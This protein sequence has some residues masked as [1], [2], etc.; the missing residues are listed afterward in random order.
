MPSIQLIQPI[1]IPLVSSSKAMSQSR[2]AP[3]QLFDSSIKFHS[4]SIIS[5]SKAISQSRTAPFYP[6]L[7]ASCCRCQRWD[8]AYRVLTEMKR[9][10]LRPLD[11]R[12]SRLTTA[13]GGAGE[14]RDKVLQLLELLR[15]TDSPEQTR[16]STGSAQFGRR[17][18]QSGAAEP[19][20]ERQAAR[21]I[22]PSDDT[23]GY[24]SDEGG[25]GDA[26]QRTAAVLGGAVSSA[27]PNPPLTAGVDEALSPEVA[28]LS[29]DCERSLDD[30][31][32][33][34]IRPGDDVFLSEL[35]AAASAKDSV[36]AV[37]L[38]DGMRAAGYRP[39]PGAYAC[40]IR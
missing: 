22:P 7:A 4:L 34:E 8:V 5:C 19:R 27:I 37:Q 2:A 10:G 1:S 25:R 33:G 6:P 14:A 15:S 32:A 39:H 16:P 24:L 40:A 13:P 23:G 28:A 35:K 9:I 26:N 3:L 29:A 31:L 20:E 36:R 17:D 11:L 12:P 18:Q 38:L 21:H 30:L